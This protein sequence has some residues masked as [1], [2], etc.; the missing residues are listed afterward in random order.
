MITGK[1]TFILILS[2]LGIGIGSY[3]LFRKS[4]TQLKREILQKVPDADKVQFAALLDQMTRQE[5]M[6]TAQIMQYTES[7]PKSITDKIDPLLKVRVAAIS[8]KYNIFT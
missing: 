5:L 6:D 7:T 8:K 4:N 2:G 3:I 1:Q